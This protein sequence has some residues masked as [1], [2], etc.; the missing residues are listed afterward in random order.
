MKGALGSPNLP[1]LSGPRIEL[2]C[3][4]CRRVHGHPAGE[5]GGTATCPEC[6]RTFHAPE[7]VPV[8][9]M[10][11]ED[12]AQ[13][14]WLRALYETVRTSLLAPKTFFS[15][16]P[17][18][19]GWFAP[20]SYAGIMSALSAVGG[21]LWLFVLPEAE[22]GGLKLSVSTYPEL[23]LLRVLETVTVLAFYAALVHLAVLLLK[24][25]A[26]WMQTTAR[27]VAY[28][29]GALLLAL[30]PYPVGLPLAGL[31][32][33]VL[34]AVGLREAQELTTGKAVVAALS[35]VLLFTILV[36]RLFLAP[37]PG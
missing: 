7:T 37:P 35:P 3:P 6:G 13:L 20:L 36:A 27:V 11:W 34:C 21:S 33:C 16:M 9:Y 31:W 25:G 18:A 10:A 22:L 14:G 1:L 26:A 19:G 32:T 23:A 24:G 15:R 30:V 12:K 8:I 4:G 29:T 28:A 2:I 5:R 17:I